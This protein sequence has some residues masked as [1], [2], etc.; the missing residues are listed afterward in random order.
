MKS[1]QGHGLPFFPTNSTGKS[2]RHGTEFDLSVKLREKLELHS[3]YTYVI[4]RDANKN[5][6]SRRPRHEFF[7]RVRRSFQTEKQ[8]VEI[9]IK[10]VA[11]NYDAYPTNWSQRKMPD[12]TVTGLNIGWQLGGIAIYSGISNLFDVNNSDVWGYRNPGRAVYLTAK[13]CG[14]NF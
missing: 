5:I 12:Y 14:K 13:K 9:N 2:R 6:E 8:Y 3:N 1:L 7:M 10:N 11:D 4:S